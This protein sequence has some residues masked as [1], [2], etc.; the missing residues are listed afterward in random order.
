[1]CFSGHQPVHQWFYEHKQ[2][3]YFF[4]YIPRSSKRS[5]TKKKKRKKNYADNFHQ[6][7]PSTCENENSVVDIWKH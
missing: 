1:M 5:V 3:F 6:H 2:D 7:K 4:I